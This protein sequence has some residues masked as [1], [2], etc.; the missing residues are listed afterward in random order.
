MLVTYRRVGESVHIDDTIEIFVLAVTPGKVKLGIRAPE[1]VRITRSALLLTVQEENA[2]A[3]RPPAHVEAALTYFT[4]RK[5]GQ[6][7]V[8]P[9]PRP[10]RFPGDQVQREDL[11]ASGSAGS[12]QEAPAAK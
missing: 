5:S 7:I 2:S 4:G 6:S 12:V 10:A 8:Q 9:S 11:R 3:S 1:Q